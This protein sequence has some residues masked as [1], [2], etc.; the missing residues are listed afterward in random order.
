MSVTK[1]EVRHI[2]HLARLRVSEDRLD[3]LASEL[4]GILDWIEQLDE[5]DVEGVEAMTTAVESSLPM[6]EDKVTAA[7]DRDAVLKNAPKS[8]EGFFVVPKAVE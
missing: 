3:T 5:V 1:D 2:A 4:N 6:R 7:G 8:E